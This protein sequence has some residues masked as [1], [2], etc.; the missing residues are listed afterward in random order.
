MKK[1][2]IK[3][4]NLAPES[5]ALLLQQFPPQLEKVTAS[6]ITLEHGVL[7]DEEIAIEDICVIGYQ[8]TSYLETLVV[9]IDGSCTRNSDNGIL[10]ITLS[11]APSIAPVCS[12]EVL[13]QKLFQPVCPVPITVIPE[14]QLFN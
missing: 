6:H 3:K 14:T 10:H 13:L 1:F 4:L 8:S 2:G 5:R 7:S 11:T 12:N 9:A